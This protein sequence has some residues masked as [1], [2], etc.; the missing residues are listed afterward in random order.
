MPL[1]RSMQLPVG[2]I[3]SLIRKAGYACLA[4]AI[5]V[6]SNYAF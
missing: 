5:A 3:S 2:L 6:T 4:P 1:V